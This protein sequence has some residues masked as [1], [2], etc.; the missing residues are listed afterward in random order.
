[1]KYLVVAFV[2]AAGFL[3]AHLT[4]SIGAADPTP[5]PPAPANVPPN[6]NIDPDGFVKNAT[7]AMKQRESRR[8]SEEDFIKMSK[9]DGVIVLDARSK[10]MY[11][12]LHVKGAINLSFPDIDAVSV[13]KV[14]PDKSAKI[15][16][17]CNN[18]FTP[19]PGVKN[20]ERGKADPKVALAMR[21]KSAP[22]SLN[23]STQA[24]LFQYGYRN[25]YELGPLV[26]PAKT[27]IELV[28]TKK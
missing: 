24:A 16:I 23:L 20:P 7:A 1:M 12:L 14:L 6:P 27:K 2:F 17:Y 22:A 11:D 4:G 5:A 13:T 15:L 21:P 8:L 25:V 18:N 26:D 9:E 19:A 10:E 3:A 28:S